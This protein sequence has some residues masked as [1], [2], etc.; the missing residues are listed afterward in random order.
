MEITKN[1]DPWLVKV[2]MMIKSGTCD[3][4]KWNC[5]SGCSTPAL[6]RMNPPAFEKDKKKFSIG[7]KIPRGARWRL[8]RFFGETTQRQPEDQELPIRMIIENKKVDCV[9]GNGLFRAIANY[10]G[11]RPPLSCG[12]PSGRQ[13]DSQA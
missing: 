3:G 6:L 4:R 5:M 12:D 13:E 2:M 11:G 9:L 1:R 10:G 8:L 7:G